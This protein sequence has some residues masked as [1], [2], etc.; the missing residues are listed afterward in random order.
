MGRRL[1]TRAGA[2]YGAVVDEGSRQRASGLPPGTR[3]G[4]YTLMRRFAMGGMAELY[5]AH[6]RGAEGFGKIVALKRIHPHLAA[7][8]E[9]TNM[10]LDEARLAAALDHPHI[11]HVL[12]FGESDGEHYLTMEYVHG[13]H[14]LDVMRAHSGRPLPLDVAVQI[15]GAVA[16]ALHHVHE[17]RGPDGRAQGLVHRD[18]SP[19]NVLVSYE[20][21]VKLTDFGIAKAVD[22]TSATRTGTF[23]GK[24]GYASPEQVRGDALDRRSDIFA[25]GIL[26]YETTTGVRTFAGP[27]EFAVLG[28]VARG[29]WVPLEEID[30]AYPAPLHAIVAR[31]L[32][33]DPAE[34]FATAEDF[35]HEL[36]EAG[37][38]LALRTS[39]TRVRD[40]MREAFGEPPPIAA[41]DELRLATR[42]PTVVA[43]TS[44]AAE[45]P[46]PRRARATLLPWIGAAAV[47]SG[48]LAWV[49][50]RPEASSAPSVDPQPARATGPARSE[51][52][53]AAVSA[54]VEP[55]PPAIVVPAPIVMPAPPAET[56]TPPEAEPAPAPATSKPKR[57][58]AK[59]PR[60]KASSSATA[61]SGLEDL[62]PPGHGR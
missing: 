54:A 34:R 24:L 58:R 33:H 7:N 19:S 52:T 48:V 10:F 3:L 15:V 14:L 36:D 12:D 51:P 8:P 21:T 35:A 22:L 30:A 62:Y 18:V 61:K 2:R 9:F 32:A 17:L 11:V 16:R 31:A 46:E 53:A 49:A 4:R 41:D 38:A 27:N 59:K 25:L 28:R 5:L 60:A 37:R 57:R 29:D 26:L 13:R 23:K 20:G 43:A 40:T 47:V 44:M 45:R 1:R 50:L 39:P 56:A 42:E 55:V 6:Q